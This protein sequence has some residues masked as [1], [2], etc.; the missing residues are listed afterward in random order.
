M[1][2]ITAAELQRSQGGRTRYLRTDEGHSPARAALLRVVS[3]CRRGQMIDRRRVFLTFAAMSAATLLAGAVRA[4]AFQ[5]FVPFLVDLD[6]WKGEKTEGVSMQ[7]PGNNMDSATR[8][9]TRGNANLEA[10]VIVGAAAQGALSVQQTGVKI[11]TGDQR[12]S[13]SNI[14]GFPV[15]QTFNV[16]DKSGAILIGLANNALFSLSFNGVADDEALALAKKFNWKALQ[17]AVK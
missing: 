4:Q 5:R 8:K 16:K 9:Y 11:E 3:I 7:M 6:G 2:G 17:G 12:M 14:D 1:C 15:T 13:T 10:Q